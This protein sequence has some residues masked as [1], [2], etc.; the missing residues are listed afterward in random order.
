MNQRLEYLAGHIEQETARLKEQARND[1]DPRV[2]LEIVLAINNW[3]SDLIG[4]YLEET[5]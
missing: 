1:P 2:V 3:L 4:W 5:E